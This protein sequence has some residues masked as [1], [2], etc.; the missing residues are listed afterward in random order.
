[1]ADDD[2]NSVKKTNTWSREPEE[3]IWDVESRG[4]VPVRDAWGAVRPMTAK[5]QPAVNFR[6]VEMVSKASCEFKKEY[7]AAGARWGEDLEPWKEKAD[8][9]AGKWA[10]HAR[11]TKLIERV[12]SND[13]TV[14]RDSGIILVHYFNIPIRVSVWNH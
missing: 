14:R 8:D 4:P 12:A 6:G 9:L 7:G 10:F 3:N 2:E 13:L 1:M 11:V 5:W